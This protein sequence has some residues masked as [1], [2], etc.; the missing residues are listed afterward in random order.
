MPVAGAGNGEWKSHSGDLGVTSDVKMY[1][2]ER[3]AVSYL[4]GIRLS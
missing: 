2:R 3:I 4:D 1:I